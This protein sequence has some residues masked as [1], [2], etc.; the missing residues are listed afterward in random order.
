METLFSVR[1][2]NVSLDD[3]LICAVGTH[4]NIIVYKESGKYMWNEYIS[5]PHPL[6]GCFESLAGCV[7]DMQDQMRFDGRE[8][9]KLTFPD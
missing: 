1:P 2:D 5:K 8:K 9:V 6:P 3:I 7:S 4:A